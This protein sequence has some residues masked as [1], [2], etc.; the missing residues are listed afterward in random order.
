MSAD[1]LAAA[2]NLVREYAVFF[3]RE[4]PWEMTSLVLT[5][6]IAIVAALLTGLNASSKTWCVGWIIILIV[7]LPVEACALY[8]VVSKHNRLL[9][10][11]AESE[12]IDVDEAMRA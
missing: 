12:V 1:A 10:R 11:L 4:D 5:A 8:K 7:A 9:D 2:D 6:L 3:Q